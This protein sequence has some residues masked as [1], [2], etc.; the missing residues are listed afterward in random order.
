MTA[1]C[2]LTCFESYLDILRCKHFK[3]DYQSWS[4][5]PK[6]YLHF[7]S[8]ILLPQCNIFY[9]L[10]VYNFLASP[11]KSNIIC[12]CHYIT[13]TYVRSKRNS[14]ML[15]T[16]EPYLT[17]LLQPTTITNYDPN[18]FHL[19]SLTVLLCS[20]CFDMLRDAFHSGCRKSFMFS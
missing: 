5:K 13:F 4:F 1:F 6:N 20:G 9:M 17:P 16:F 15:K 8:N 3:S 14:R 2:S 7:V 18:R 10:Q 11:A 12:F 19:Q